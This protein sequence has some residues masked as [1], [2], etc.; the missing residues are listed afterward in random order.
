[1]L[2][3]LLN[4]FE[5]YLPFEESE[6]ELLKGRVVERRI[7]RRQLIL[8]EGFPCKYYSFVVE[9]CFKMYGVDKKRL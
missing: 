2:Q 4:H 9:G 6:K 8:K 7:K 3:P 5:S 1:M